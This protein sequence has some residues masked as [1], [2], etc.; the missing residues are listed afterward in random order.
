MPPSGEGPEGGYRKKIRS[1]RDLEYR[2][3]DERG[4]DEEETDGTRDYEQLVA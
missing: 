4:K 3:D 1:C 2:G